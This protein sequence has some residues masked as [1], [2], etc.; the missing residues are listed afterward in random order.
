[1][2][3]LEEDL[4]AHSI[5]GID[6]APFIYLWER[7]PQYAPL[8]EALFRYLKRP[9]VQGIT[10]MITLIEACVQPKR[11]GRQDLIDAYEHALLDSQQVRTLLIDA[12]LARRA[13]GLR[14]TLN[15]RVP[16]ALQMAAALQAGAT[17]FVTND[18]RLTAVRQIQVLL[19]DDYLAQ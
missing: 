14:A 3:G 17:L 6:T 11:R 18:R 5:I 16:D 7:H 10:S 8:S 4:S 9:D 15:L 12:P 1:M 2:G 19:L 13:V